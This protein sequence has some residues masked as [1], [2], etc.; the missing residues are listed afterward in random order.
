MSSSPT[1]TAVDVTMPQMGV[2]VAE[3]T[4]AEWKKRLGD[5]VERDETIVEISTDKIETEIPSPAAGRVT[6]I[7]VE[8]GV[9]VAVGEVLARIDTGSKP[10][11]AHADEDEPEAPQAEPTRQR[12][13]RACAADL[14]GGPAHRRRASHRPGAGRRAPACAG[15]SRR[16]TC[17]RSSRVRSRKARG[18][19]RVLHM[20]SPYVEERLRRSRR[21]SRTRHRRRAALAHAPED[22]RAHA[23]LA[24]HGGALHDDRR[25]RHVRRS[26]RHAGGCRTCRSSRARSIDALRKYPLMNATLEGDQLTIHDEVNL[27]H[28]GLARRERAD[29]AGGARRAPALAR[30]PRGARS[31]TSPRGRATTS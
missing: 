17:W 30:G 24:G 20:E 6:E 25:G 2:S 16:R 10:G 14:A 3:G 28:R 8:V 21:P 23:P 7:L 9:T 15:A 11:Q 19:S 1:S 31:R 29:R 4:I 26:R 5:W 27:G 22:R 13:C 12:A 18:P